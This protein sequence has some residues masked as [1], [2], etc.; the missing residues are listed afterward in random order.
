MTNIRRQLTLFVKQTDAETIEKVRKKFNPRQSE[1]I[2]C[3]VTLCRE[4]EL[5]DIDQV[6]NN[7]KQLKQKIINIKF[8]RVIRFDNGKGVLIPAAIENP[9]FQELRQRLLAGIVDK[10]RLQEPHITLM[11]PRNSTCTDSIFEQILKTKIPN[12]LTFNRISV[13]EQEGDNIWKIIK[14]IELLN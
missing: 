13:I 3:H 2:S 6:L 8:G 10:P 14:E 4:D 7:L 1:L 12:K 9:E 11:H 5:E